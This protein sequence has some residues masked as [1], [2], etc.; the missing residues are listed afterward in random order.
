MGTS[1]DSYTDHDKIDDEPDDTCNVG[2]HDGDEVLA[3]A[4]F[5]SRSFQDSLNCRRSLFEKRFIFGNLSFRALDTA[6]L[7]LLGRCKDATAA[8][9]VLLA[10]TAAEDI[11]ALCPLS[12]NTFGVPDNNTEEDSH[13]G[14]VEEDDAHTG[15]EAEPTD[16]L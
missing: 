10:A 5:S 4:A 15:E 8:D 9:G 16:G 2:E 6:V 3:K 7:S 14:Q 13:D 12:C 1:V 11:T